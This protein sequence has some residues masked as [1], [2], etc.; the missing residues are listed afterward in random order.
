MLY[1]LRGFI[2]IISFYFTWCVLH[3]FILNIMCYI[4]TGKYIP[5]AGKSLFLLEMICMVLWLMY[6][7]LLW[8][9]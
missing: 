5:H 6:Y 2:L 1:I 7:L 9:N 3:N 4:K 8:K